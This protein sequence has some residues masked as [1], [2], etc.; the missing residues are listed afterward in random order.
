MIYVAPALSLG[1]KGKNQRKADAV[2]VSKVPGSVKGVFRRNCDIFKVKKRC[3]RGEEG[4][5]PSP[6]WPHG[7]RSSQTFRF[8]KFARPR[9]H[10]VLNLIHSYDHFNFT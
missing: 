7:R 9:L 6:R 3:F 4:V 1:R 10:I 8:V 2:L 5:A